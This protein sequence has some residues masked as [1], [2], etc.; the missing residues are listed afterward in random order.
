MQAIAGMSADTAGSDRPMGIARLEDIGFPDI[1]VGSVRGTSA[2]RPRRNLKKAA[3]FAGTAV[4]TVAGSVHGTSAGKP[5]RSS[6]TTGC[7]DADSAVD[8][9]HDTFADRPR[10]NRLEDID[11]AAVVDIVA[12]SVEVVGSVRGFAIRFRHCQAQKLHSDNIRDYL[13]NKPVLLFGSLQDFLCNKPDIPANCYLILLAHQKYRY[14]CPVFQGLLG[15]PY[16]RL[17]HSGRIS[18]IPP[19]ARNS[20]SCIRKDQCNRQGRQ[21]NNP[22]LPCIAAQ[23]A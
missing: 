8:I 6:V 19:Y 4:G 20:I 15:H 21:G 7:F 17:D 14:A 13:C 5:R 18:C 11:L 22:R 10:R 12:G 1:A 16:R 9:A 23:I 2:D 3:G